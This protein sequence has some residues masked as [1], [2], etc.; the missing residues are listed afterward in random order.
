M[1][2]Q[3]DST[4]RRRFLGTAS[5]LL[6]LAA[7]AAPDAALALGSS[8][9]LTV[10]DRDGGAPLNVHGHAGRSYVAARPG[11]R[12]ALRIANRT[13]GRVLVVM[14]VDGVNIVS[15]QTASWHQGGYVLAPWQSCEVAGWRKSNEEIAAFEFTALPDSY[16]AR[17]GRPD[18]VGVIGMAVFHERVALPASLAPPAVL[19]R[20]AA[21][22]E[23]GAEARGRTGNGSRNGNGNEVDA[24]SAAN[25]ADAASRRWADSAAAAPQA[26]PQAAE[27]LG[28]GHGARETSYASTTSFVRA[29]ARPSEVVSLLYD[30]VENL[31]RAGVIA[32]VHGSTHPTPR[33][34]PRS[35]AHSRYVPDP[36]AR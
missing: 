6:A 8:V 17:T 2:R 20:D 32:E 31:V 27:R 12:Y 24:P 1:N 23:G 25:A 3:P 9:E 26:A 4:P 7:C 29:S 13:G 28:T 18:D 11:A 5:A 16:A 15:G 30:R 10:I 22:A 33:P 21:K 34:F 36:P 35:T 14:A 19:G